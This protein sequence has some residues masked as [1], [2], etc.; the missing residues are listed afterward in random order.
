MPSVRWQW[1]PCSKPTR[2]IRG[3]PWDWPSWLSWI[4]DLIGF[5]AQSGRALFWVGIGVIVVGG[6]YGLASG[7]MEDYG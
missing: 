1:T 6:I 7:I 2:G 5:V 4:G 3:R